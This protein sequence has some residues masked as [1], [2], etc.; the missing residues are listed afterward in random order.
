MISKVPFNSDD[1]PVFLGCQTL[2]P[3]NMQ[4]IIKTLPAEKGKV[5]CIMPFLL[6]KCMSKQSIVL[7]PLLYSVAGRC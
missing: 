5:G 1:F 7:V 2:P 6:I 3:R 4:G